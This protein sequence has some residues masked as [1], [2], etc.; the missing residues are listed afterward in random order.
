LKETPIGTTRK[1][2]KAILKTH[3]WG[4]GGFHFDVF[5]NEEANDDEEWLC[6]CLG[7]YQHFDCSWTEVFA[8][9][10]FDKNGK[11]DFIEVS[12]AWIGL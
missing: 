2:V 11:L 3:T 8:E 6:R 12:H 10:H 7:S 5:K 9:W 1:E 4:K